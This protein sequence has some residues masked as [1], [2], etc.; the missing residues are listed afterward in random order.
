MQDTQDHDPHAVVINLPKEPA[1]LVATLV[2]TAGNTR[3]WRLS[4][5]AAGQTEWS[6]H[7]LVDSL[8]DAPTAHVLLVA[9]G[10][11]DPRAV[12]TVRIEGDEW[13]AAE[14]LGIDLAREMA[15]GM[16]NLARCALRDRP[17][18]AV[19]ERSRTGQ[20][21]NAWMPPDEKTAD[22]WLSD[23]VEP[24][25]RRE[26]VAMHLPSRDL[27]QERNAALGSILVIAGGPGEGY[28]YHGPY[29]RVEDVANEPLG[30]KTWECVELTNPMATALA[31]V[32]DENH[33]PAQIVTSAWQARA[34]LLSHG[35]H[36]SLLQ[37][38]NTLLAAS[39]AAG[40]ELADESRERLK[41]E[42]GAKAANLCGDDPREQERALEEVE[43]FVSSVDDELGSDVL[44]LAMDVGVD[45]AETALR[46]LHA[47][48]QERVA[49]GQRGG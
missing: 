38:L 37:E 39:G 43:A 28:T 13:R 9:R 49:Q 29:Q 32:N 11:R 1:F 41:S 8:F 18:M 20:V 14:M 23:A 36:K 35:E 46:R 44:I 10:S 27:Y 16:V 48:H 25:R 47:Q 4:P 7:T 45:K 26:L 6:E 42:L 31:E 5:P 3:A 15:P 34:N 33:T 2:D 40:Y 21:L 17:A 30:S 22:I 24:G 12:M 19:V